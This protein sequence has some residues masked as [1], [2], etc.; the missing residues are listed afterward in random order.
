MPSFLAN[1]KYSD[2]CHRIWCLI[3]VYNLSIKYSNFC[4]KIKI[5]Q[6]PLTLENGLV[7]FEELSLP[8]T[9]YIGKWTCLV[10]GVEDFTRP[11][12]FILLNA[13][14]VLQFTGLKNDILDVGKY[15]KFLV[16]GKPFEPHHEKTFLCHMRTTKA[17]IS[18][19]IRHSDQR[20]C[21]SLP[22]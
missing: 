1:G 11:T 19:H 12:I 16:S 4:K 3:I 6:T 5:Y 7:Q 15:T 13:P 18:M 21:W 10:W 14:G 2:Q 22:G 17:E 8:D 20:L 9:P